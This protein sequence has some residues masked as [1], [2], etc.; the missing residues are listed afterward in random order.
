MKKFLTCIFLLN[1]WS[2]AWAQSLHSSKM[3]SVTVAASTRYSPASVFRRLITGSN[4]RKEW[5]TPVRMPVFQMGK[6]G[7]KIYKMGG[8]QQTK[9]LSLLDR[10]GREWV[11]RTVDK[12]VEGALPPTLR[13]TIA[14]K[15][16]QDLVSAAHPYAAVVVGSL[17]KALHISAPQPILYFVPDSE[18]LGPYRKDLGNTVCFL[19]QREPT[20]NGQDASDTED[21][22]EKTSTKQGQYVLQEEVLKARLLDML[23]ADWDRHPEQW[24]WGKQDSANATWFYPIPRDRDQAFFKSGGLFPRFAKFMALQHLNW[25]KKDPRGIRKLSAKSWLFDQHFL[26]SLDA[27]HWQKAT[28][29]MKLLLTD[30]LI[31]EAVKKLPPEI[32]AINGSRIA[33]TLKSR[34][35]GLGEEVMKYYQ[36]LAQT[37][38][39][40]GTSKKEWFRVRGEGENLVVSLHELKP[41]GKMGRTVYERVIRPKETRQLILEGAEGDDRF[42]IEESARARIKLKVYGAQGHDSYD[43][44]PD[45]RTIVY[46]SKEDYSPAS[47]NRNHNSRILSRPPGQ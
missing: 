24:L 14:E 8:G 37:V 7:F 6:Q 47:R 26:N 21:L 1:L 27:D 17:A 2:A 12:Y 45:T 44:G 5:K 10:Q 42:T 23:V 35:D 41:D 3:D 15:I 18:S 34:R 11:L 29:E 30:A 22:L 13:N 38:T 43:I 28:S 25:F 33:S 40:R 32:W 36:F 20:R 39:V 9:S 46:D 4:Y 31:D 16:T 19:E